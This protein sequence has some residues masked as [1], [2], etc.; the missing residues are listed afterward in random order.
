MQY[1]GSLELVDCL[2]RYLAIDI[3]FFPG[4]SIGYWMMKL[5]LLEAIL[6]SVI[7]VG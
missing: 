1:Q 2:C 4:S 3:K 7:F 6:S 5:S